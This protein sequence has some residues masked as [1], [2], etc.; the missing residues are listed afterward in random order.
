MSVMKITAAVLA[1][2]VAGSAFAATR[3]HA[4]RPVADAVYSASVV[5]VTNN[6][7]V[8]DAEV[9]S[10]T[11][12]AR[13]DARGAFSIVLPAGRPE[14][15][16]IRRSGYDDLVIIVTL[17]VPASGLPP[18][19]SPAVPPPVPSPPAPATP[20]GMTPR[21]PVTVKMSNG[22]TVILDD[23]SIRFAY[24]IPFSSPVT[25]ETAT[26]CRKDGTAF[27]PDRTEFVRIVGPA[28]ATAS[29][30]CC[31]LGG[32]LAV[33]VEMKNGD[34][35]QVFFSDSCF[36][37]DVVLVGRERDSAQFLYLK[38]SEIASAEFP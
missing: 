22:Q 5:D 14:S 21:K 27:N 35:S 28:T 23:D 25:S 10:G 3:S 4:V 12:T 11:R 16:T 24:I 1:V 18:I 36:G 8:I 17:A 34:K 29:E 13:T 15:L 20:V 38:F 31:K 32:V 7:P 37:Y 26:F 9:T 6:R 33:N 19:V 30:A 2:F